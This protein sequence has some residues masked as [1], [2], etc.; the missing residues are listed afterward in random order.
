MYI[1]SFSVT[2]LNAGEHYQ[3]HSEVCE[4][5][6]RYDA[7]HLNVESLAAQYASMLSEEFA[8]L[9]VVR[10]SSYTSLLQEADATRDTSFR[11]I[12]GVVAGYCKHYDRATATAAK[13][14]RVLIKA[15]GN[16][17]SDSLHAET[18]ILSNLCEEMTG[19][20]SRETEI[21]GLTSWVGMLQKQNNDYK[22]IESKRMTEKSLKP[23][24]KL[25]NTRKNLDATYRSIT[26]RINALIIVNGEPA[27]SEFVAQLN[28][29]IEKSALRIAQN[30]G[31]NAKK[32]LIHQTPAT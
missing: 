14:L 10:K 17:V 3:F 9:K 15:H 21:L 12:A 1:D 19:T 30:R 2:A 18:A 31:R 4:L 25:R 13:K 22:D 24:T 20:Y 5:I 7:S 29:R 28:K 6:A 27:Y 11:G 23:T 32:R 16:V 26:T 8:V